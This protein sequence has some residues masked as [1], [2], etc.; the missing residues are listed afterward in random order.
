MKE[1]TEI[2]AGRHFWHK[3]EV[4]MQRISELKWQA[5]LTTDTAIVN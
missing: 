3:L 2:V 5:S 1:M 4:F